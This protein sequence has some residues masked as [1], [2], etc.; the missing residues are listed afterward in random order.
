[1]KSCKDCKFYQR[2]PGYPS[3]YDNCTRKRTSITLVDPVRGGTKR[4]NTTPLSHYIKCDSE[5]TSRAPWKCG[6][7]ARHFQPK[8]TTPED[9]HL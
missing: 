1:M 9:Y 7:Q 5:R 6:V 8:A 2:A 3:E 4:V